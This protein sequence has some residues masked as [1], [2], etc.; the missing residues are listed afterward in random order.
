M[1]WIT[2]RKIMHVSSNAR[3]PANFFLV[4]GQCLY[5]V[6]CDSQCSVGKF[7]ALVGYT[8]FLDSFFIDATCNY[9]LFFNVVTL[10]N[11]FNVLLYSL[12]FQSIGRYTQDYYHP[13]GYPN[14]SPKQ[15]PSIFLRILSSLLQLR[16]QCVP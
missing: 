14:L 5:V 7:L 8:T 1:I 6:R 10:Y 13:I 3:V 9:W 12:H 11:S 15:R 16:T 4:D 2:V